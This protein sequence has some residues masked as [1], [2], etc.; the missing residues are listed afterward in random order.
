MRCT[1]RRVRD[2]VQTCYDR[3]TVQFVDIARKM[4]RFSMYQV[5]FKLPHSPLQRSTLQ[6]L[7]HPSSA[8]VSNKTQTVVIPHS[9]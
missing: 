4:N 7:Q 5:E 1:W 6:S 8:V 2:L 3:P 9:L